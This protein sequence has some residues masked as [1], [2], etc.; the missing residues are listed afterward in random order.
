MLPYLTYSPYLLQIQGATIFDFTEFSN[1]TDNPVIFAV[2]NGYRILHHLEDIGDDFK[3]SYWAREPNDG[4][5]PLLLEINHEPYYD[6]DYEL[7]EQITE[8]LIVTCVRKEI[9]SIKIEKTYP[10]SDDETLIDFKI[11]DKGKFID[12]IDSNNPFLKSIYQHL[13]DFAIYLKDYHLNYIVDDYTEEKKAH[14][15]KDTSDRLNDIWAKL[16]YHYK[17]TNLIDDK[18]LSGYKSI[19]EYLKEVVKVFA[20]NRD[21]VTYTSWRNIDFVLRYSCYEFG[22][23]KIIFYDRDDN[24]NY[25]LYVILGKNEL[26]MKYHKKQDTILIYQGEK[27]VIPPVMY[28]GSAIFFDKIYAIIGSFASDLYRGRVKI[29]A[30]AD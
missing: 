29:D 9:K 23:N 11:D 10:G 6:D 15:I 28:E 20:D 13:L 1:I 4:E 12:E 14:H 30:L 5:Y 7:M 2:H 18:T 8:T 3:Y 25:T 24:G 27:Y 17:F 21:K 16:D 19:T 26:I 22:D